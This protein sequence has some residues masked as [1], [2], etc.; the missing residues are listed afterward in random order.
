MGQAEP[1][2]QHPERRGPPDP[3]D[4]PGQAVPAA[5]GHGAQGDL[6]R[7]RLPRLPVD[8]RH[9]RGVHRL[10]R[11]LGGPVRG[12]QG[13]SARPARHLRHPQRGVGR[14][15]ARVGGRRL[16]LVRAR[17][18][19]NQPR[20]HH[21]LRLQH[22]RDGQVPQRRRAALAVDRGRRLPRRDV[23]LRGPQPAL[24][25]ATPWTPTTTAGP[26]ASATS[27]AAAWARRSWTT[28]STS[29]AASTTWPTWPAPSTTGRPWRGR[30]TWP[31]S[32]SSASTAPGGSRPPS[33]TPTP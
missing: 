10:R 14:G 20:R 1:R 32:C 22:R 4:R 12:R 11:G 16:H 9:R 3:L 25:R 31:A 30:G 15:D 5:A 18:P 24:R 17:L 8:L 7:R 23:R 13:A 28:P 21:R 19:P 29:S 6:V 2:R 33:S 27:S 26:R